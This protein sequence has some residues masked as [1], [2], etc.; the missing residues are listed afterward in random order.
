MTY[1]SQPMREKF[2]KNILKQLSAH[3]FSTVT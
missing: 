1:L 2:P 3:M